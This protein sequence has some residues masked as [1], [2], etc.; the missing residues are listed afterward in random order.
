MTL[1]CLLAHA[2]VPGPFPAMPDGETTAAED[3]SRMMWQMHFCRDMLPLRAT[4]Y[5]TA[6]LPRLQSFGSDVRLRPAVDSLPE[7]NWTWAT[8]TA[9][10]WP[11]DDGRGDDMAGRNHITRLGDGLWNNYI[12]AWEPGG[13]YFTGARFYG[14]L[15]LHDLTGL[16]A[17]DWPARRARLQAGVE[18]IYGRAPDGAAGLRVEWRIDSVRDVRLSWP[19]FDRACRCMTEGG[20]RLANPFRE[21]TVTGDV[22]NPSGYVARNTPVITGT[23]RVPAG[24]GRGAKI[25][26]VVI[27]GGDESLWDTMAPAGIAVFF[28]NN[29]LLQP[30]RGG[31]D[32]SSYLIGL[33]GEG[34]WRAPE[35]WGTLV[36]WGW[37]VSRLI[38]FFE[39][40]AN[41]TPVDARRVGV[42]GHSRYGKAALVAMAYD[43]RVAFAFPSSSGA[44]G[45]VQ[46]RRHWGEEMENIAA[47]PAAYYWLAGGSLRYVG[48]HPAST[49]GYMPRRV[50][51]MPVD[52]ESLLALCA[53]RPVFIG[54]GRPQAGEAWVD[55]YGQ[56][57]SAVAASPVYE[58]LGGRGLVMTDVMDFRGQAV[59][60]PV[61]N[62]D[63]IEGDIAYRNH[64]G[65]HTAAPNYPAFLAFIRKYIHTNKK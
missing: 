38:D 57:L 36:A 27:F 13:D 21:Y 16:T 10:T 29:Q 53:P 2:Q 62:R 8:G 28:F 37:G 35:D 14:P 19:R 60:M 4:H 30:D 23:L 11:G 42:T 55:P 63:Y 46:S 26:V 45:A 44:M 25:P 32:M 34:R 1:S 6:I 12:Q 33:A 7:G 48:L 20:E 65:G 49:D 52:A 22:V 39:S 54:C 24:T 56:Y 18:E 41:T 59:P 58:L 50:M 17:A 51:D 47:D 15:A 31:Q 3:L 64:G 9:T 40:P 43:R 5:R 61:I